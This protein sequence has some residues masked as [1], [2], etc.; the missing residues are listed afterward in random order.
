MPTMLT[1]PKAAGIFHSQLVQCNANERVQPTNVSVITFDGRCQNERGCG[2]V[3]PERQRE[4]Q[5]E[6]ERER[7]YQVASPYRSATEAQ[8][9]GSRVVHHKYFR[10][11]SSSQML[12][13]TEHRIRDPDQLVSRNG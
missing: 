4:K 12:M 8:R 10:T 9:R 11:F 1:I 2:H 5:R 7:E 6:R 13:R 3:T